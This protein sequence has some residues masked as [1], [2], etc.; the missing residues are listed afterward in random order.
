VN[1]L[2]YSF[3]QQCLRSG[4]T[5]RKDNAPQNLSLLKRIVLNLIRLDT[6]D[7]TKGSL[8]LKRKGAACGDDVFSVLRR[9]SGGPDVLRRSAGAILLVRK[10]NK[11]GLSLD[12]VNRTF[13]PNS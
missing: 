4:S 7:K 8:R 9:Y 2:R 5:V 3:I 10:R 13:N 1:G 11:N 6:T 12:G